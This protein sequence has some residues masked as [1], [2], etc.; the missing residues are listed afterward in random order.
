[1]WFSLAVGLLTHVY[2]VCNRYYTGIV[3]EHS[4]GPDLWDSVHIKWDTEEGEEEDHDWVCPWELQVCHGETS[5][6]RS[7][8]PNANGM[9]VRNAA[10][11]ALIPF[12][13]CHTAADEDSPLSIAQKRGLDIELIVLLNKE[14]LKGLTKY[15]K[16]INGTKV[17]LPPKGYRYQRSGGTVISTSVDGTAELQ[18]PKEDEIFWEGSWTDEKRKVADD[19]LKKITRQR[20]I[21]PF[22]TPV[23]YQGLK[24]Q[25]YTSIIKTPMD[26]G[27]V[28]SRFKG[29][30]GEDQYP[31]PKDYY[32]ELRLVFENAK[33]YNPPG[34][35]LHRKAVTFLN[36]FE[37]WWRDEKNQIAVAEREALMRKRKAFDKESAYKK[38]KMLS[39]GGGTPFSTAGQGYMQSMSM[40]HMTPQ[41]GSGLSFT[42]PSN[43]N[44]SLGAAGGDGGT[45]SDRKSTVKCG[46]CGG[47]G[48]NRRT[49]PHQYG[50][51]TATPP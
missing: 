21:G 41:A 47:D 8:L 24:L 18:F 25:D 13:G 43:P 26:L 32:R 2:S 10:E 38:K 37:D 1:V 51:S 39:L 42:M 9:V 49:C 7:A 48:H 3:V 34:S 28:E 36:Q 4:H 46:I 23:D 33:R 50:S 31:T 35:D 17:R 45:D 16:L 11:A 20:G 15:S 29:T 44:L 22:L 40:E 19:V 5:A 12:G 27:T 30:D 14:T 6:R